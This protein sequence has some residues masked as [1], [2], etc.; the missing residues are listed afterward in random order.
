MRVMVLM[1]GTSKEREISLRSGENVAVALQQKGYEVQKI[2]FK[3][4]SIQDLI[5]CNADVAYII[6]HGKP[7]ED[8][9]VQGM[10]EI[11]DIPYTGSGVMASSIAINKKFS[12]RIFN[13]M[14]IP[15]SKYVEL[16][17]NEGLNI[18]KNKI[19]SVLKFPVILKPVS[20][21]S[22]IGVIKINDSDQLSDILIKNKDIYS[23]Q[24]AE[25]FHAGKEVT[26]GILGND[27]DLNA[28]PVLE[29]VPENDFYD[30]EAKY[31][32]GLTK[33]IIPA[34]LDEELTEKVKKTAIQAHNALGC[35]GVSRVD[36]I[37][38]GNEIYVLE[39][40]TIPGMTETS[41]LPAQAKAAGIE[42]PELVDKIVKL[43]MERGN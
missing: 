41:D 10:L 12:K 8:G 30:Y 6:L 20:E 40:N 5:N 27:T 19:E 28:L 24:I 35:Y 39:V 37:V 4:N 9:I 38:S 7:G 22:S 43:G 14:N 26:V 33:F 16:N 13:A 23:E 11:L 3:E 36:M 25:E 42:F 29:L 18:W 32:K 21:G 31:K 2:D 15:T 17:E 1:G 34:E